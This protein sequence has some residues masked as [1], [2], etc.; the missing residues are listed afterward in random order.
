MLWSFHAT[1]KSWTHEDI[2]W[3]GRRYVAVQFSRG[4]ENAAIEQCEAIIYNL[5]TLWG[6]LDPTTV[7]MSL[8]LSGFYAAT[9]RYRD[10]MALHEEILTLVLDAGEADSSSNRAQAA[11]VAKQHF[12]AIKRLHQ[13]TG[14]WFGAFSRYSQ[15]GEQLLNEFGDEDAWVDFQPLEDEDT[16]AVRRRPVLASRSGNEAMVGRSR[17]LAGGGGGK[18]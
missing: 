17:V 10:A 16:A 13:S 11:L 8:V 9:E 15:L 7:E 2:V 12:D 4:N 18:V 5:T 1:Q 3:L 6:P 14:D